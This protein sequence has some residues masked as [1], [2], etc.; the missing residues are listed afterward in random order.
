MT[1]FVFAVSRGGDAIVR[2]ISERF[3]PTRLL[4]GLR[5][6]LVRSQ[7]GAES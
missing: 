4:A 5:G 6:C 3:N 2:P 7:Y 1:C